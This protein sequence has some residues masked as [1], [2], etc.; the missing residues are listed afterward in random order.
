MLFLRF[1]DIKGNSFLLTVTHSGKSSES[2]VRGLPKT[3]ENPY[4]VEYAA[5]FRVPQDFGCPGA[6]LITNF[7]EREVYLVQIAVHGFSGGPV[8][9]SANTWIHSSKDN[10]ESRIIFKN[11]VRKFIFYWIVS[12]L[13]QNNNAPFFLFL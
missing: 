10:P 8:F 5:D 6:A 11:Q 2:Y 9:F 13:W 12:L 4:I 7:L 1:L 3:S